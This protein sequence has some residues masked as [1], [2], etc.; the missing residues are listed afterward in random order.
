MNVGKLTPA[1]VLQD[2]G[3]SDKTYKL[4]AE[5]IEGFAD[6]LEALKQAIHK[7]LAT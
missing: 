3:F 7:V 4:S 1:L 5:K 6:G 2:Q